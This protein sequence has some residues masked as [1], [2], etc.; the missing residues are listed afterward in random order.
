MSQISIEN[1]IEGINQNRISGRASYNPK[2][3]TG[4]GP[5]PPQHYHKDVHLADRVQFNSPVDRQGQPW[6]VDDYLSYRYLSHAMDMTG[7]R[8]DKNY[9][10]YTQETVANFLGN[11]LNPRW[12][13]QATVT[14]GGAGAWRGGFV[15]DALEKHKDV[16]PPMGKPNG[17]VESDHGGN[18]TVV[19][20]NPFPIHL[21]AVLK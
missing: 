9:R 1:L 6:S 13:G 15:E 11:G 20:P 16:V 21:D 14:R 5:L 12:A 19:H 8:N 18:Y 3:I 2:N 17:K 10:G 7:Y 4:V